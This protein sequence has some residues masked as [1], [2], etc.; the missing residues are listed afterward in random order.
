MASLGQPPI[1]GEG[2]NG[3]PIGGGTIQEQYAAITDPVAKTEFW[4]KHKAALIAKPA[5]ASK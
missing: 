3:S 1:N 4:R 5:T 2:G